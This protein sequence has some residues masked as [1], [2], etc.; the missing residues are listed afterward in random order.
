MKQ[1]LGRN[2]LYY[3]PKTNHLHTIACDTNPKLKDGHFEKKKQI[4]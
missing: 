4:E 2:Q 3:S 1:Y